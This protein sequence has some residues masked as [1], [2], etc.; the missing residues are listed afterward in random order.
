MREQMTHG[1]VGSVDGVEAEVEA[2]PAKPRRRIRKV[3]RSCWGSIE[4]KK[5][6]A[7]DATLIIIRASR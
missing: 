4:G 3:G 6:E 2:Q 1:S 5:A 7:F